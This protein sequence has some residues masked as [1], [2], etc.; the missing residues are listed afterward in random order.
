MYT[1]YP[2]RRLILKLNLVPVFHN[3]T[4]HEEFGL[5]RLDM[6]T[7]T[8]NGVKGS[9]GPMSDELMKD[10]LRHIC[11]AWYLRMQHRR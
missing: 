7:Y 5:V 1:G 9:Y 8:G 2:H 3:L 6:A 10:A 11:M 4:R